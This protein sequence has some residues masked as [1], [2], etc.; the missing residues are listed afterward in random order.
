M[1]KTY[2]APELNR[3]A[4]DVED[5]VTASA[6]LDTVNGGKEGMELILDILGQMLN[7]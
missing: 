5:V 3:E 6:G 4:F 2:E 1:K 7:P